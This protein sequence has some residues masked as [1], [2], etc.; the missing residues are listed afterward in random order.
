M[1]A[2]IEREAF[3]KLL[4]LRDLK[5]FEVAVLGET[6]LDDPL[7]VVDIH[8]VKQEVSAASAD[9]DPQDV[10]R[11]VD[12]MMNKGI[13]PINSERFWIHTHP[14][15]G[16]GSANPSAKDM[17]TWNSPENAKRNFL[18]MMIISKTGE[19][20]CKV[21]F[22]VDPSPLMSVKIPQL[23]YEVETDVEIID[24]PEYTSKLH[25]DL[26][27]FYGENTYSAIPVDV[28][29]QYFPNRFKDLREKYEL[30][31][32]EEKPT[33]F[34]QHGMNNYTNYGVVGSRN[35]KKRRPLTIKPETI[36]GVLVLV[37][38]IATQ[39]AGL[40]DSRMQKIFEKYEVTG[41]EYITNCIK[42]FNKI[43]PKVDANSILASIIACPKIINR[44]GILDPKAISLDEKVTF[45]NTIGL[46][47]SDA[48]K[49]IDKINSTYC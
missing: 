5:P 4:F 42:Q 40:D 43:S 18:V 24:D 44:T 29:K 15:T 27:D 45:V 30:Y 33:Y 26:I 38:D 37:S 23:K 8:L 7:H 32:H 17:A 13:P 46:C 2:K 47:M 19:I 6:K 11:H 3:E 49:V 39:V 22:L 48:S 35:Q 20:T 21:R 16:T 9:L 34:T 12:E 31:V 14:M 10:F 41:K 1:K 25:E 36:P 28:L